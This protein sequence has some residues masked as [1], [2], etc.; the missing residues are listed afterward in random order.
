MQSAIHSTCCWMLTSML[1]STD[2][3]PGPGDGEQVRE[4]LHAET[5]VGARPGRPR[6]LQGAPAAAADVDAQ[7][8]AG[9]GVEAG[10]VDQH[11]EVVVAG[12]GLDARRA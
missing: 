1:V 2:G 6:V 3:L 8:R 12:G 11:V 9:H 10:G 5:E 4:P 7:Q